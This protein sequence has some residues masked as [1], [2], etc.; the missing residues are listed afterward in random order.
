M[1]FDK[2][3]LNKLMYKIYLDSAMN[4]DITYTAKYNSIW[5]MSLKQFGGTTVT[6]LK[7][8]RSKKLKNPRY[9]RVEE[10]EEIIKSLPFKFLYSKNNFLKIDSKKNYIVMVI[11]RSSN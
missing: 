11:L 5:S 10:V 7:V 1:Y 9:P 8:Y 3:K 4:P 6:Y 2:K